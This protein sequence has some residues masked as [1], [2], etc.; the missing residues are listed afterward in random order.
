MGLQGLQHHAALQARC[1]SLPISYGARA[2]LRRRE[3][4]RFREQD[5]RR[6]HGWHRLS[7]RYYQRPVRLQYHEC[8][9]LV[10]GAGGGVRAAPSL[11]EQN[12][13]GGSRWQTTARSNGLR[14]SRMSSALT[15]IPYEATAEHFDLVINAP[16]RASLSNIAPRF[17]NGVAEVS[18]PMTSSTAREPT[19]FMELREEKG[20]AKK[21]ADG[22][23]MLI[24]QARGKHADWRGASRIPRVKTYDLVCR[25]IRERG[26]VTPRKRRGIL[27]TVFLLLVAAALPL[28]PSSG[29][30]LPIAGSNPEVTPYMKLEAARA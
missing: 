2:K 26:E 11:L 17:P 18:S 22:L 5:S 15:R 6:Q 3:H 13:K 8:L 19:P 12:P 20:G 14:R 24:E 21:V 1:L 29:R 4:A 7:H 25:L 23:G 9:I 27:T 30:R 10:L 28:A 16:Q